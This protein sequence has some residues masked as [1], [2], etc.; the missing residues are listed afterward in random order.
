MTRSPRLRN[1]HS[2]IR[3]LLDRALQRKYADTAYT[4]DP[5]RLWEDIKKERERVFS[6]D[7]RQLRERLTSIR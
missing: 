3:T 4:T 2:A 7:G 6:M 1:I 5:K